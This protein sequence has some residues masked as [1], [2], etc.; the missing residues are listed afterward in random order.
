MKY[1]DLLLVIFMCCVLLS[2]VLLSCELNTHPTLFVFLLLLSACLCVCLSVHIC[3]VL[4]T[5]NAV[6]VTMLLA[7][8]GDLLGTTSQK[9]TPFKAIAYM[10]E[11]S[12]P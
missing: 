11:V 4:E 9:L 1:S 7:I 3:N 10:Y 8:L 12:R 6:G 2:C 5:H